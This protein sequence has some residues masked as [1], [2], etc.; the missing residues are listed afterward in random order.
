MKAQHPCFL[1]VDDSEDDRFLIVH[2]LREH[3]KD[4]L[5]CVNSGNEAI[6]YLNGDA[7]FADRRKFPYP[8]IVMTDLKMPDGD[9]FHL[10]Q[11]LKKNPA[12]AVIPTIVLSASRNLDDVKHAYALGA[13]CYL[14]KP[15]KHADLNTL[16]GELIHFWDKCE[17][18]EIDTEGK[19]LETHSTGKMGEHLPKFADK[20]TRD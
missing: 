5:H 18:P 14:H 10:L 19:M 16:M 3:W 9:G 1:V 4:T 2:A 17:V 7:E 11:N 8:T 12:W 13:S 20:E 6:R 15:G